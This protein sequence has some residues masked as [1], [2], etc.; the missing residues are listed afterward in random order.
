MQNAF[1]FLLENYSK[2]KEKIKKKLLEF[3]EVLGN[4]HDA[5]K[6]YEKTIKF[7]YINANTYFSIER[8]RHVSRNQFTFKYF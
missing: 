7:V 6:T 1:S 4:D 8:S 5:T 3:F 2:D